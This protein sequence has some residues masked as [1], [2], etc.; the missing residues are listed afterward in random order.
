MKAVMTRIRRLEGRLN[1]SIEADWVRNPNAR[2]RLIVREAGSMGS[3]DGA[4]CKRTQ[5]EG[6][7]LL[8]LVCLG[9]CRQDSQQLSDE[10]L[11]RW[12]ES[13]PIYRV[14]GTAV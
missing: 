4:P 10:Q 12:I 1:R 8:E 14:D 11:N 3:L 7:Q 5:C 9:Q 13:F 2:L 6:G